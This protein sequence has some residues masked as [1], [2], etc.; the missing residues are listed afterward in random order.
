MANN[1]TAGDII[2]YPKWCGEYNSPAWIKFSIYERKITKRG[3][4]WKTIGLYM[5]ESAQMP[6]T[7]SWENERL[8][9]WSNNFLNGLADHM[10]NSNPAQ[11]GSILQNALSGNPLEGWKTI[12]EGMT[13]RN[14]SIGQTALNFVKRAAVDKGSQVAGTL[15]K[16][17]NA[18]GSTLN[19]STIL[20][21]GLGISKNPYLTAVFKGVDFRTFE[22]SF[23]FFPHSKEEVDVINNIVKSFRKAALPSY[24]QNISGDQ[25]LDYPMDF[26]IAYMWQNKKNEYIHQFKPSILTALDINFTGNGQWTSMPN[27]MPASIIINMRFSETK[28]VVKSDV[29]EGF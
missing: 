6:S 22:F 16:L 9:Q 12:A 20:G 27:G 7:V 29:D 19:Q 24:N 17:N 14:S 10:A 13:G 8:S 5:P 23:R 26:D 28:I 21:A 4:L 2:K 18:D 11:A 1:D 25:I 3:N 15:F